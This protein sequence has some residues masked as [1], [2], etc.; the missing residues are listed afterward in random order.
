MHIDQVAA[1]LYTLR[2]HLKTPAEI[3]DTLRKVRRIGY[4]AVQVSGM[5][6]IEE[7]ELNRI[8]RGE[9]LTCCATHE[10][11][12]RILNETDLVIERLHSLNCRY[13]AYPFPSDF[14]CA[15]RQSLFALVAKLDAAGERMRK[16]DQVLTY[17]N[18]GMELQRVDGK[19][20]LEWIYEKTG[21]DNLQGELDTYWIQYGGCDPAA[22]CRKL[23]RRLPLIHLKDYAPRG[24]TPSFAPVGYGNL[25]MPAIIRAAETSGCRWFIVEQDDCYGEDPFAELARSFRYLETLA[26]A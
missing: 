3:A 8:L 12:H 15:S 21:A 20:A 10:P 24:A 25:D 4:R 9:G 5:G 23:D 1:Q 18:H 16:A 19:T 13:T 14:D 6:P 26:T 2:E 7:T 17:H 11:P 22:W